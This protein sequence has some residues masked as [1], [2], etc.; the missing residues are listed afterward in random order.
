ML[1]SPATQKARNFSG[2]TAVLSIQEKC[3]F[4]RGE[5]DAGEGNAGGL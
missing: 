2:N 4:A 1:Y 5:P 3:R